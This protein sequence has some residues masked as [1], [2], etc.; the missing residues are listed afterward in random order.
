[1]ASFGMP[2]SS[3]RCG[4]SVIQQVF[5]EY[6]IEHLTLYLPSYKIDGG[7]SWTLQSHVFPFTELVLH[8]GLP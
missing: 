5:A 2:G 8:L 6:L 3:L 4:N 7:D 1:M